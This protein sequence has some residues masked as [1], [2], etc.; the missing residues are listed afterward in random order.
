MLD[1]Q[2]L[3]LATGADKYHLALQCQEETLDRSASRARE[4]RPGM[5]ASMDTKAPS[6][7]LD[8][9]PNRLPIAVSFG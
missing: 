7:V 6:V 8:Q 1:A 5:P 3:S 2:L 9:I 4:T